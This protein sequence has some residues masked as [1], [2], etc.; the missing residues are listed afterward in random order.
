[1]DVYGGPGNDQ[2]LPKDPLVECE[3]CEKLRVFGG[4]GNDKIQG[5]FGVEGTEIFGGLGNDK[6]I[7]AVG[8]ATTD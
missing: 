7:M 6:I 8:T 5:I 3:G 1:M 2:I 4:E